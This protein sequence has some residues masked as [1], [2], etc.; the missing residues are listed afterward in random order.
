ML[1]KC[2]NIP[3]PHLSSVSYLGRFL[4]AGY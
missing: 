2:R 3:K 1:D 4:G